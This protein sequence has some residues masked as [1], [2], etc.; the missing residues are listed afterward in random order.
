MIIGLLVA[1]I[2]IYLIV[3][4]ISRL[5]LDDDK[6]PTKTEFNCEAVGENQN[7]VINNDT[8]DNTVITAKKCDTLTIT[9]KDVKTRVITFGEHDDHKAYDDVTQR[10]LLKDESFTLT[11]N[12]TGSF[13]VHDHED[14]KVEAKFFVKPN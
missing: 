12:E 9:N 11:L 5:Y 13:V 3:S 1:T 6:T 2:S 14:Q 8:F 7:L 10:K 4:N